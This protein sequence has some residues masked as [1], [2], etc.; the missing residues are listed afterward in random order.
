MR[1]LRDH[2]HVVTGVCADGALLADL[3]AEGFVVDAL[4]LARSLST[5]GAGARVPR[6][7]SFVS[8]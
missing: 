5:R 7:V 2:G 8:S 1:T 4:P 6:V 3:R